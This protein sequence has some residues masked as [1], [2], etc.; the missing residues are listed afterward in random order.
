MTD[1]IRKDSTVSDSMN[2]IRKR[3]MASWLMK[4]KIINVIHAILSVFNN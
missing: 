3:I 1:F 2:L 4:A